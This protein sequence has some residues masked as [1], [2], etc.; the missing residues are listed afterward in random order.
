MSQSQELVT[1][2]PALVELGRLVAQAQVLAESLEAGPEDLD[3]RLSLARFSMH[4]PMDSGTI[5]WLDQMPEALSDGA[6]VLILRG[7]TEESAERPASALEL[8]SRAAKSSPRSYAA[9]FHCGRL[10]AVL[11]RYEESIPE[12]QA[13]SQL[14]PDTAEPYYA[15]GIACKEAGLLNEAMEA[16]AQAIDLNP[17]FPDT[18][19]VAADVLGQAGEPEAAEE[20]LL[21]LRTF[22]A[23][24]QALRERITAMEPEGRPAP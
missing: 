7:L 24:A 8:Y 6:E 11:R 16:L 15:L 17:L 14:S 5:A 4:V 12:L 9:R 2:G 1:S 22:F 10:L 21:R 3:A 13:A 23:E 19:L 20:M 18:Y